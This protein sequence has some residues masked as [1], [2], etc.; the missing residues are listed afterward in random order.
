MRRFQKRL[1]VFRWVNALNEYKLAKCQKAG[2]W[3]TKAWVKWR[4]QN[5]SD[6]RVMKN[7][8]SKPLWRDV[9]VKYRL[10]VACITKWIVLWDDCTTQ[11]TLHHK[12]E[13]RL[14]PRKY[15]L[16]YE[17]YWL[18]QSFLYAFRIRT[19]NRNI[20]NEMP[21]NHSRVLLWRPKFINDSR[22]DTTRK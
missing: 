20:P 1:F 9:I 7:R 21:P 3:G 19:K 10:Y 12:W 16:G 11:Q 4:P 14:T 15:V 22:Q 17:T 8:L 6:L 13:N 18:S 2:E 5:K